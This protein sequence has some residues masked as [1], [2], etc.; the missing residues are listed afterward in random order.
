MIIGKDEMELPE[1]AAITDQ[2]RL[3]VDIVMA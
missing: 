1:A 2:L 3:P